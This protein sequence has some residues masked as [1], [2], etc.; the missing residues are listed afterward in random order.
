MRGFLTKME[1]LLFVSFVAFKISALVLQDFLCKHNK[2]IIFLI[3]FWGNLMIW[4]IKIL[5]KKEA[6]LLQN[7]VV[8]LNSGVLLNVTF[9]WRFSHC[10]L[11]RTCLLCGASWVF[12]KS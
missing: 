11:F 12:S 3:Y 8:C 2:V 5:K 4:P 7:G 10:C 1:Q 9:I 6:G